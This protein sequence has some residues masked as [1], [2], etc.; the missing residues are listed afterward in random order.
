MLK[1]GRSCLRTYLSWAAG[2]LLLG[3]ITRSSLAFS[4]VFSYLYLFCHYYEL[5]IKKV[6]FFGR[7]VWSVV[8]CD[9]V[10]LLLG[11]SGG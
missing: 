2:W 4:C 11:V 6:L 1:S 5:N 7:I 10:C 3:A 8:L 9:L